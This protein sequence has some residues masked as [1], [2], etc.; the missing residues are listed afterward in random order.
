[1][2]ILVNEYSA[3]A[4]EIVS[5]ALQDNKRALIV[6]ERTFGKGSVQ[7]IVK[8]PDGS[9]LKLT[10]ARYYTPSGVSI[11]AEGIK[12]DIEI[13]DVEV[14]AFS[15]AVIKQKGSRENDIQGH[16]KGD[17]EKAAEAKSEDKGEESSNSPLAWWNNVASAKD[18]GLSAK[19]KL[20]KGDYQI[21]QA[22]NYLKTWKTLKIMTK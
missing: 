6:G 4:S 13:E 22:F 19:Q 21:Y 14:E 2:I 8:L 11:Q 10:V 15:K 12:P 9:G 17:K 16:L 3:S 1:M 20:L 18:E 7:S 5:G